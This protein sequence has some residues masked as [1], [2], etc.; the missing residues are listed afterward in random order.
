MKKI[1]RLVTTSV[2]T[3]TLVACGEA[4][5]SVSNG[6]NTSSSVSSTTSAFANVSAITLSAASDVLTQ[7]LGTQKVV[8]VQAALNANTN[9]NLALEWYV[10][11]TKSNQTGRVFEYTPAAAGT[12]EIQA[13]S[14]T[15]LS[16]KVAVTVGAQLFSV[17]KVNVVDSNTVELTAPGGATVTVA[18]NT[19]LPESYYDLTR[20]VYVLELKTALAQGSNTAVTLARTGFANAVATISYDTRKLL[21]DEEALGLLEIDANGV[22]QLER[23]HILEADG[24]KYEG[25]EDYEISFVSENLTGTLAY[26]LEMVSAPAGV[27]LTTTQES[28]TTIEDDN[29]G[30]IT[31]PFEVDET[32]A[33]GLYTWNFTL[34]TLP[35]KTVK[36]NVTKPEQTLTLETY[37]I[38][39]KDYSLV[40]RS[41]STNDADFDGVKANADGSFTVEKPYLVDDADTTSYKQFEFTVLAEN[42]TVP[43]ALLSTETEI[44]VMS[45]SLVGPNNSAVMQSTY[46]GIASPI[47]PDTF[48][49]NEDLVVLQNVDASTPVGTYTYTVKV[50][51]G[52]TVLSTKDV[53]V[54]ITAPTA[55]LV[56]FISLAGGEPEE[57]EDVIEIERPVATGF[58]AIT[59]RIDA[60][61]TNLESLSA[62]TEALSNSFISSNDNL[63]KA[64][65]AFKK[66]STGPDTGITLDEANRANTRIAIELGTDVD[67]SDSDLVDT[68]VTLNPETYPY[69]ES[70]DNV[71]YLDGSVL[72]VDLDEDDVLDAGD[73]SAE[74]TFSVDHTTTLG[75]Y[76]FT[77]TVGTLTS[78]TT[79]KVIAPVKSIDVTLLDNLTL[80][81]GE[82]VELVADEDDGKYYINLDDDGSVDIEF[83]E[84]FFTNFATSTT[85]PESL[86]FTLKRTYPTVN[87]QFTNTVNVEVN[88]G[89]NNYLSS[90]ALLEIITS[91]VGADTLDSTF[92]DGNIV[93]DAVGEYKFE[94]SAGGVTETIIIVV[95]EYPTFEIE[96][97][98]D[99]TNDT[100]G[101]KL[102]E[103]VYMILGDVETELQFVLNPIN[104][105]GDEF[106]IELTVEYFDGEVYWLSGLDDAYE[107]TL[108][109]NDDGKIVITLDETLLDDLD[110]EDDDDVEADSDL[111]TVFL[112]NTLVIVTIS[113]IDS[114]ENSFSTSVA[115]YFDPTP[116]NLDE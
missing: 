12:F 2:L 6:T 87:D 39:D 10:N 92:G 35:T 49:S 43:T 30:G 34:G 16:N 66:V 52:T 9:P 4:S 19:V 106:D 24:D 47:L 37:E 17:S 23:P 20:G 18:N 91:E 59:V 51:Q 14:G 36:I 115:I 27:T 93:L 103:N 83:D 70:E 5:S 44:N 78:T 116:D 112:E 13:K 3:L 57:V 107:I 54:K 48:R 32:T 73:S 86:A 77:Y 67:G 76:T 46:Y 82:P 89:A 74:F 71:A 81:E 68:M 45:M 56:S 41:N 55:S 11:G 25:S 110:L 21:I 75:T 108:T 94:L 105:S 8:V 80:V 33:L 79:V 65:L 61:V 113:G 104:L 69:F 98:T 7:T 102:D 29:A 53:V 64:L 63:K 85:A 42:F 62:P 22:I 50:I 72:L 58:N 95:E 38:D 1:L 26:K 100:E 60:E 114:D 109:L 40:V 15:V 84:V 90:T 31:I 97:L 99:L 28:Q 111:G 96:S 101:F 88:A